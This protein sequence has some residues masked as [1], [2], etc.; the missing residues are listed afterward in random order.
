MMIHF[1][2]EFDFLEMILKNS[3]S[4]VDKIQMRWKNASLN[5]NWLGNVAF[6][7]YDVA[8]DISN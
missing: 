5:N 1:R 4:I 7:R 8:Y 6:H 3:L 2:F